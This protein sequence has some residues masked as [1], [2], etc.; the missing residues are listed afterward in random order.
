MF[1]HLVNPNI[2]ELM[3][4]WMPSMAIFKRKSTCNEISSKMPTMEIFNH[5][6]EFL[7]YSFDF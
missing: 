5:N 3:Y 2:N 4:L 1:L 6:L 7:A